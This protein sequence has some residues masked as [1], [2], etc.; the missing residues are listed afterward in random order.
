MPEYAAIAAQGK[1]WRLVQKTPPLAA[2]ALGHSSEGF[3]GPAEWDSAQQA[4]AA[5]SRIGLGR[6]TV[7]GSHK[8]FY[9]RGIFFCVRCAAYGIVRGIALL[10]PCSGHLNKAGRYA[11]DRVKAGLPPWPRHEWPLSEQEAPTAGICC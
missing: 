2:L 4:A 7:H 1:R 5:C 6:G 10:R 9:R 11:L 3:F 8:L